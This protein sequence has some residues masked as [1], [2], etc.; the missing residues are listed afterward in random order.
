MMKTREHSEEEDDERRAKPREEQTADPSGPVH[1][2][3]VA[4][5]GGADDDDPLGPGPETA[6]LW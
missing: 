3:H 2:D 5:S 6:L 4:H 1:G